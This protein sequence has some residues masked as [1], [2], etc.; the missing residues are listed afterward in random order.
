M[1]KLLDGCDNRCV[2]CS[3]T[4]ERVS[5]LAEPAAR[6]LIAE[7]RARGVESLV[8]SGGE[9]TAHAGLPALIALARELGF[10]RVS[11]FTNGRRFADRGYARSLRLA[12]LDSALV[13][14]HGP[15]AETHAS[16]AGVAGGFEE[17]LPGI[18]NLLEQGVDVL[19]NTVVCKL[20]YLR[21]EDLVGF[22]G[23]RFRNRVRL[24]ISD[25]FSTVRV[26][27]NAW[28]HVPYAELK[29]ALH[30]A[31]IEAS[32][33]GLPCCTVL[34]PLCV[35]DP[36]FMDALELRE[37][38]G[39]TLVAED[40]APGLAWKKPKFRAHRR[41]LPTCRACCL[42]PVCAG[43]AKSYPVYGDERE[44]FRPFVGLDPGGLLA[45]NRER[46]R[47]THPAGQGE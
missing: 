1:L 29:P 37:E 30:G 31:L 39:A 15:D 14:L 27:G 40:A 16:V 33:T 32:R 12:G 35:L 28:L 10:A 13:S 6:A 44:F 4:H 42:R 43:L 21:L 38:E 9:P 19:L 41:Y 17:T 2:F 25:L 18:D 26:F 7:M 8:F 5:R 24:Q 47:K 3:E 36:L 11:V 34:F 23:R 20:N 46:D 22:V 45:A